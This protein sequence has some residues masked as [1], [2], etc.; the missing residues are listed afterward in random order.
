MPRLASWRRA[1]GLTVLP[2]FN[3]LPIFPTGAMIPIPYLLI[4]LSKL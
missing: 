3:T 2:I 4:F 1:M